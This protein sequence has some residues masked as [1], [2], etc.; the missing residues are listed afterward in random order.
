[1]KAGAFARARAM[2]AAIIAAAAMPPGDQRAALEGIEPY[3]SRGK[4]QG[5]LGNKHSK[6]R[7]AMDKRAAVKARNRR[8]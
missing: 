7:V 5:L 6:H 1:M 8:R 4:G 3:R 2:F